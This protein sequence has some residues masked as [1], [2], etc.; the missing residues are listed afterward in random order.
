MYRQKIRVIYRYVRDPHNFRAFLTLDL[1]HSSYFPGR[2]FLPILLLTDHAPAPHEGCGAETMGREPGFQI[3]R[4]GAL[5]NVCR[6]EPPCSEIDLLMLR[7]QTSQKAQ[8][9]D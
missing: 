2:P 6:T 5:I 9:Y 3:D 8:V 7:L 4:P 1:S